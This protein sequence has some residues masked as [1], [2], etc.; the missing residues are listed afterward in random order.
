[1]S[2]GGAVLDASALLCVLF[3]E[4]GAD[5]VEGL[6]A[7]ARISAVNYGEVV[8]KLSDRGVLTEA[9]LADLNDLAIEVIDFDRALARD[10]GLLRP[11]TRSRGLS[12][13]ARSCLALAARL[14]ATALTADRAW[15]D[16]DV[17]ATIRLIR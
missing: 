11:M 6:M 17:G 15:A 9:T 7:G 1:M 16:L 13:G 8:A 14:N 2:E 4:P 5:V 3:D 12:F 10:S